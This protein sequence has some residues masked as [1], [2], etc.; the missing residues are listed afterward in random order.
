[1]KKIILKREYDQ[2][3]MAQNLHILSYAKKKI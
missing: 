3:N 1:M 2:F